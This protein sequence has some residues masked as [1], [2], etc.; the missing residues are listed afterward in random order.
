MDVAD[1]PAVREKLK[2]V[3]PIDMLVNN[4]GVNTLQHFLDIT[5]EEYDR[6]GYMTMIL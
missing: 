1:I 2:D 6:C 3:G 4:A 5:V